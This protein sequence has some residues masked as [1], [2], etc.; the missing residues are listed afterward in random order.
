[1][2]PTKKP[3]MPERAGRMPRGPFSANCPTRAILDQI[4][5]KWSVLILLAI[6]DE[7]VR[8]NELKRTVEGISQKVLTQ[9]LQR[10]ER[11]GL[12]QRQVLSLKPIAVAYAIT[13]HGLGLA[14]I[15][16][17]LRAWSIATLKQT[18]AAQARFDQQ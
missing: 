1:M 3:A 7:P 18:L 12:L 9:S 16:E 2:T 11:N 5:D 10:L 17:Q 13:P 8:F 4:A 6:A 14:A 15:V